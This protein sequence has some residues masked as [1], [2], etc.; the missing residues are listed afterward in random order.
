[1][2]INLSARNLLD[3]DLASRV[4]A[5]LAQHEFP[6]EQLMLEITE[7][8][9][10]T[11]P[12]RAG[13]VLNALRATGAGISIDDFGTGNASLSYVAGLPATEIKIDRSFVADICADK[14]AEAI[15]RSIVDLA[16]DLN[17]RVVAEG[18]E[19]R[20]VLERLAALG[21][22]VG[23]GYLISRPAP[24]AE[25]TAWLASSGPDASRQSGAAKRSGASPLARAQR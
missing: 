16:R 9:T 21:C 8:A 10:M 5:L 1:M 11:D 6:P 7:S 24:A 18:I 19:T 2:A 22:D 20:D 23:Q 17:L 4:A 14:R 25:L 13:E 3:R 15:V 12:T